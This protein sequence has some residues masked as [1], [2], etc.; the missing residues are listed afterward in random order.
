MPENNSDPLY[1]RWTVLDHLLKELIQSY[2]IPRDYIRDLQYAKSLINFYL[3]DPD[4]PDRSREL[5]RI[6]SF[7][8]NAEMG[9][10]NIAKNEG[11]EFVDDWDQKLYDA[12]EGKEVFKYHKLQSKFIAGMPANFDFVRFNFK[13]PIAEERFYEICEYEGVIIEYDDNDSSVFVFGEK[14]NITNALKEM[15]SLFQEQLQEA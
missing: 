9:L 12:S 6:E 14:A 2:E 1:Q 7:L 8:N 3:E 4:H 10:M 5:P 15:A 11:K 13:S